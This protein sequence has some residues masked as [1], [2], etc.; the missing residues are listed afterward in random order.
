MRLTKSDLKK[1]IREEIYNLKRKPITE[2][3]RRATDFYGDLKHGKAIHSLLKGK[4]DSRKV[5]NYLD[6]LGGGDDVKNARI[7]DFI[8]RYANLDTRKYDNI[9]SYHLLD[10]LMK[11]LETMYKDFLM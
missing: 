1:L 6:K 4:W 5:E 3:S 2:A 11:K 7:I 9:P 8:A 10:D